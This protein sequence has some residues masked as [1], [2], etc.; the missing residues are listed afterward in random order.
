LGFT[1]AEIKEIVDLRRLGREPCLHVHA[2]LQ[3]KIA[4][5]DRRLRD[6]TTLRKKL[7]RL[8]AGSGR[9]GNR[10]KVTAAVCPHIEHGPLATDAKQ[11][12]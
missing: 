10:G 8:V 7:K 11:G 5:L 12:G 6:L 9:I 4:D 2:M 1:L 3:R